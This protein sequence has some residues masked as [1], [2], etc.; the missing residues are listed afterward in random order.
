MHLP[1]YLSGGQSCFS[2]NKL[3]MAKIL[4]LETATEVCSAG[5]AQDGVLCSLAEIRQS[6][7]H[8]AQITLLIARALEEAA[9]TFQ[10]LDA[11]A[12]SAGPGSYTSLRI[13]WSTAKGLAYS[14]GL[15]LLRI[16]TLQALA[17]R[18]LRQ[19]D[20]TDILCCPMIDARRM[21]VYMALFDGFGNEITPPS[22]LILEKDSFDSWFGAGHPVLF[23][24]NG[25]E[26]YQPMLAQQPL[27]LFFPLSTSADTFP[28]LAE[29]AFQSREFV[30]LA[31]AEPLYLKPP[32]ITKPK[33]LL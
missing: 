23:T 7:D 26:K 5:I 28:L 31:Y 15:P 16:S 27:A 11:I 19:A 6:G 14:L 18:G 13:G 17:L 12:V 3:Q 21:E 20:R 22:A 9:L 33:A 25:A 8:A 1:I 4:C 29:N 32:N 2:T 24:G 30:D 10:D